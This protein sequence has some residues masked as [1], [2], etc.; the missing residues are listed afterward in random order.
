M[1][2]HFECWD[3]Y[4]YRELSSFNYNYN[5]LGL[6]VY[7][8]VQA[9]RL[10]RRSITGLLIFY[11]NHNP[12]KSLKWIQ[13][14]KNLCPFSFLL[15]FKE[16]NFNRVFLIN[17]FSFTIFIYLK[18]FSSIFHIHYVFICWRISSSFFVSKVFFN[19]FPIYFLSSV[20]FLCSVLM[21]IIKLL[22]LLYF[23]RQFDIKQ[24]NYFR[25]VIH[26]INI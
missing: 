7:L 9:S 13:E 1:Y 10:L 16:I 19:S 2:V 26:W 21:E 12:F 5:F 14:I 23:L 22:S 17:G 25:N 8:Y 4:V 24:F 6:N 3:K 20:C 15:Y 18:T 11:V